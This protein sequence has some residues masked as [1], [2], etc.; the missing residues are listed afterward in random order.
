MRKDVECPYC[1]SWQ[2]ICHEDGYG[3]QENEDYEQEC[4]ECGNIF[5][6]T[7]SILFCYEARAA[8]CLNGDAP[9]QYEITE[10]YPPEFAT[11]RCTICGKEK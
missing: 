8:H 3:Y 9:H 2:E 1:D 11:M 10:T 7:T 5:M 4:S 6:F